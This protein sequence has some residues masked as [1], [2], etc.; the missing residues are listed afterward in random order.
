MPY[1]G[2]HENAWPCILLQHKIEVEAIAFRRCLC[3]AVLVVAGLVSA[4]M[5]HYLGLTVG[6]GFQQWLVL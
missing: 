2:E 1:L 5:W 3:L 6:I 4:Q